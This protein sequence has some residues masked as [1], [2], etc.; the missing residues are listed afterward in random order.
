MLIDLVIIIMLVGS[1][2]TKTRDSYRVLG[3]AFD[4]NEEQ[5]RKVFK[6]RSFH[7]DRS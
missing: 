6:K 3:V 4:A 1:V 5:N 7:P 2:E